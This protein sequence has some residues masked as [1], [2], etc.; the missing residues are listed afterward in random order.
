M[1]I[2]PVCSAVNCFANTNGYCQILSDNDFGE[3]SCPF[4]KK[5]KKIK[6][7]VKAK[8]EF[9]EA[10]RAVSPETEHKQEPFTWFGRIKVI[11]DMCLQGLT[12]YQ[13]A[14]KL[15]CTPDDVLDAISKM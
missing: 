11:A 9:T 1:S 4:F 12:V 8:P 5:G 14:E 7:V 6:P 10:V 2:E 13:I 3:R 15:G